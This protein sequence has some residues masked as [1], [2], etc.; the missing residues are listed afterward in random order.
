MRTGSTKTPFSTTVMTMTD[1]I[2]YPRTDLSVTPT[3]VAG[4]YT[5]GDIFRFLLPV[6]AGMLLLWPFG[7]IPGAIIGIILAEYTTDG[8]SIDQYLWAVAQYRLGFAVGDWPATETVVD[9]T[10][11]TE[12]GTVIGIVRI[13]A[14]NTEMLSHD[15]TWD[16]LKTVNTLFK[17]VD[18]PVVFTSTQRR[19]A[20]DDYAAVSGDTVLTDH[21]AAIPVFPED[22][23]DDDDALAVLDDRCEEVRTAL[24]GADM[25]AERVTGDAFHTAVT[26]LVWTPEE[27]SRTGFTVDGEHRQVLYI[28]AYPTEL[29]V[30][31][32]ADT[33]TV[34]A[35]GLVDVVQTVRPATDEELETLD[36]EKAKAEVERLTST[37]PRRQQAM[38]QVMNDIADI[39]ELEQQQEPVL[40]YGVYI[41]ARAATRDDLDTTVDRVASALRQVDYSTPG[42]RVNDAIRT[43]SPLFRDRLAETVT[44]PGI[45]AAAGFPWAAYDTVDEDGVVVGVDE[46]N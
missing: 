33:L 45:T 43:V 14:V 16:N 24:T 11:E 37:D 26:Q 19:V 39:V 20:L 38:Q 27:V 18:Y 28:A 30:E 32:L 36:R 46:T 3:I 29:P 4:R 44:A 2:P 41:V 9:E 40:Q 6:L 8:R 12:R 25:Y 35:P 21:Y 17:T 5:F 13:G 22:I 10:V 7:G 23:D 42:L 1:T 34:D 15:H 31:W